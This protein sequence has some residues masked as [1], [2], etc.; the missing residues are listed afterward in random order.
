LGSLRSTDMGPKP[1]WVFRIFQKGVY[2]HT[3]HIWQSC[4]GI[5][6]G[7]AEGQ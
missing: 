6:L 1:F 3:R 7:E 2:E 5:G 4:N